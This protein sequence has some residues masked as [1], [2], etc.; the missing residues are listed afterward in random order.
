MN[1]KVE[2]SKK[3]FAFLPKRKNEKIESIYNIKETLE[4]NYFKEDLPH[5]NCPYNDSKENFE[6]ALKSKV[7]QY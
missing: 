3:A 4:A 5:S 1:Y 2:N 7:K 6:N